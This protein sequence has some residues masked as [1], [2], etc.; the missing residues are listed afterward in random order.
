MYAEDDEDLIER[1]SDDE[2][3]DDDAMVEE[4][5]G[6]DGADCEDALEFA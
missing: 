6:N 1:V 3:Q 4:D 2:P 5:D